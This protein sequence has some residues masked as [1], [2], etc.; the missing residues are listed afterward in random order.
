[1]QNNKLIAE[2]MDMDIAK[3][4]DEIPLGYEASEEEVVRLMG[5]KG[6]RYFDTDGWGHLPTPLSF[7]D[8]WDWLMPVLTKIARKTGY[9]LVI[10][11]GESY[12]NKYGDSPI[13]NTFGGYEDGVGA[14][15]K[16]VVDFIEWY[17]QN[18]HGKK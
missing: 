6:S 5:K 13:E 3:T 7:H 17:N 9:E 1:M 10:Y 12:W 4:S 11:S 18:K 8:S 2:F 16:A 14:I 15:W